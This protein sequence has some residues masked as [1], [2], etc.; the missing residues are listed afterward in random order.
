MELGVRISTANPVLATEFE[1]AL[2]F[3]AGILDMTWH[4]DN[5][6][7]CAIQLIDGDPGLFSDGSFAKAQLPWAEH[8]E[9]W[10]A[11]DPR[12]PLTRKEMYHGSVH[13]IGHLLGLQHNPRASSVM[14]AEDDN[15]R[16]S[17]DVTDLTSL[18]AR[19]K[20][21][22]AGMLRRVSLSATG[23]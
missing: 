20:L 2:A 15:G 13:E 12:A 8:F 9:G 1:R 19:H 18:T 7:G 17:L 16:E 22:R 21:R 5:T 3:W 6:T 23:T 4:E 10:V 14:C 11:F